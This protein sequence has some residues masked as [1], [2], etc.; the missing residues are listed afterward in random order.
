MKSRITIEVDFENGN[1]PVIQILKQNSEDVRDGL[2]SHFTQQFGGSS[3]CQIKWVGHSQTNDNIDIN[4]IHISPIKQEDLGKQ[5]TIMLEQHLLNGYFKK[6]EH[7]SKRQKNRL[8]LMS[9]AEQ[10]ITFAMNQVEKIGAST[11]L[12]NAVIKLGEARDL[13]YDHLT[14]NS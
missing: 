7:G 4:R 6:E 9:V 12:T 3:W 5:A 2:L 8:D 10:A 14:K 11:E 13:V 1:Q